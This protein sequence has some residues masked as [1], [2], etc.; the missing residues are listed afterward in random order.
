MQY[1]KSKVNYVN[2]YK[3]YTNQNQKKAINYL[4]NIPSMLFNHPSLISPPPLFKV[5]SILRKSALTSEKQFLLL[6]LLV[7][8]DII[9][10]NMIYQFCFYLYHGRFIS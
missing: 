8:C 7:W 1:N 5:I 2:T 4:Y 6:L 3:L 10:D 9:R